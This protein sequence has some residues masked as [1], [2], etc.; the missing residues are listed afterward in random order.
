LKKYNNDT[1][2]GM[3]PGNDLESPRIA[4]TDLEKDVNKAISK[5]IRKQQQR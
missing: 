3:K 2:L 5:T 4:L 1:D